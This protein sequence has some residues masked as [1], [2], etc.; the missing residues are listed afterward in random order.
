MKI[1]VLVDLA[2][3][4]AFGLALAFL[5]MQSRGSLVESFVIVGVALFCVAWAASLLSH[6]LERSWPLTALAALAM[7]WGV[8]MLLAAVGSRVLA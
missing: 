1:G 7:A 3:L 4:S 5:L 8:V 6:G 2:G